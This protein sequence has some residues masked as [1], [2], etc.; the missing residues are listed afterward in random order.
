MK[1]HLDLK[2]VFETGWQTGVYEA[3]HAGQ[4][5]VFGIYWEDVV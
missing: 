5:A 3:A 2:K 4:E 1:V